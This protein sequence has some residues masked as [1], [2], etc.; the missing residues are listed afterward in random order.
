MYLAT[1]AAQSRRGRRWSGWRSL[2]FLC[3]IAL[4]ALALAPP[5]AHWAH[6]DLRGHMIQ[7]LLLGMLAPLALVLGAPGTLLLRSL[8]HRAARGLVG[9]LALRPVHM[10]IHPLS[11][12]L[13]NIGGMYLLY[14]TP[15]YAASLHSPA[16]HALVHL[17]FLIAGY[18]FCWAIVGPDPTP[19]RPGL[20]LRLAVLF[21]GGA[22]HAVLGKLMYAY[23]WPRGTPHDLEQIEAAAQWMYYG[24][25]L[26]ELLLAI[27]FFTLWFRSS[28]SGR[29]RKQVSSE[30]A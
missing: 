17:H 28:G 21:L 5:I 16:L 19:R 25:D 24:G 10:L 12:L 22:A 8:P 13:F 7:H 27:A 18:L 14:L 11:A 26:A 4:L 2:S 3:G 30:T 23:G 20:R 29:Y 1:A 6:H 15:L 9:F